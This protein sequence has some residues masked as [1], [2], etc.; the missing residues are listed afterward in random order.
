VGEEKY[1]QALYYLGHEF[2]IQLIHGIG[3]GVVI[4]VAEKGRIGH[5]D[6]FKAL[7]PE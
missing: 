6:G 1:Y 5:H 4:G 2:K 3:S 7:V